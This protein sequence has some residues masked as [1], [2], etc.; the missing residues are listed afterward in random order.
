MQGTQVPFTA[1]KQYRQARTCGQSIRKKARPE[2]AIAMGGDT[3]GN[4]QP[5]HQTC[6]T[7]SWRFPPLDP[8]A[9]L[10]CR[11]G[12]VRLRHEQATLTSR[13]NATPAVMT[14]IRNAANQPCA[15]SHHTTKRSRRRSLPSA[16]ACARM[17]RWRAE[18]WTRSRSQLMVV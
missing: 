18:S 10:L 16:W 11:H 3:G 4:S 6:Q 2:R 17:R 5:L 12:R 8:S 9:Q 15:A 7:R 1:L 14:P 13:T